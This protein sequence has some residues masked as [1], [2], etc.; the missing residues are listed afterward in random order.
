[1]PYL[2]ILMNILIK[3]ATVIDATSPFNGQK[4]D[5]LISNGS[6][7]SIK[8]NIKAEAQKIIEAKGLCISPGWIDLFSDFA[9]PGY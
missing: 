7:S 1:M 6:I 2:R 3:Q 4:V 5:I 8:K 9:D